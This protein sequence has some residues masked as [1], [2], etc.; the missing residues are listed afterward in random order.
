MYG[1]A[2]LS[3]SVAPRLGEPQDN[4]LAQSLTRLAVCQAGSGRVP[5][6]PQKAHGT[7]T[8][9]RRAPNGAVRLPP[10]A[11]TDLRPSGAFQGGLGFV[12]WDCRG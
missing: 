7:H 1:F 4:Q 2:R 3:L 6:G 8:E 9:P 5:D 10:Y 11:D 12:V